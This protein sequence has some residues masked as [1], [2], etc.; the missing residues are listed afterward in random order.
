MIKT[1]QTKRKA[2]FVKIPVCKGKPVFSCN[3]K[4]ENVF[5]GLNSCSCIKPV[6]NKVILK[7]ILSFIALYAPGS[8]IAQAKSKG[9]FYFFFSA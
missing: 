6:G 8:G 4:I 1:A 7:G 9:L 5:V 2:A 3:C